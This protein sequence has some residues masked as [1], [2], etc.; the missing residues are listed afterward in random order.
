MLPVQLA[1]VVFSLEITAAGRARWAWARQNKDHR[2]REAFILQ[3]R[4]H[5]QGAGWPGG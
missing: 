4:E 2:A 1:T 3:G 5:S